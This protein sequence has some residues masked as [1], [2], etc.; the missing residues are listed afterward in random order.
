MIG[1]EGASTALGRVGAFTVR[2]FTVRGTLMPNISLLASELEVKNQE[3]ILY[4]FII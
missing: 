2:G 4:W 1:V 3:V